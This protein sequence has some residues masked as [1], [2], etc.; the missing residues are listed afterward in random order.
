MQC[1]NGD[2]EFGIGFNFATD[3]P[4]FYRENIAAFPSTNF[5]MLLDNTHFKLLD[6]ENF[7]LLGS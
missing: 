2:F 3:S 5:F 6:G 4:F 7:L 1:R